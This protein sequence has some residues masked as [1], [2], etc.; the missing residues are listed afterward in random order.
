MTLVWVIGSGGL[1]GGALASELSKTQSTLFNPEFRFTW[2]NTDLVYEELEKA[3][4]A[5]SNQA[6]HDPWQIY[7]AAGVGTM[8]SSEEALQQETSILDAF[9]TVLLS[10][11]YLNLK[12]GTFIFSSSAGA[13]YAG[14]REGV[15]DKY[16][17][18]APINAYGRNKLLQESIVQ[19]LHQ[20]NLGV[21]VLC[22][23][24]TTLYGVKQNAEKQQ[25]LL[26]EIARRILLNQA[27]HIYVPLETMRDYIDAD[28]AAKMIV[29]AVSQLEAK[30]GIHL[31]IIASE[32][33][34][35]IAQLLAIFKR[36]CKRNLRL[37]TRHDNRSGEYQRVVQ[38]RSEKG[39][40]SNPPLPL[41]LVEGIAKL[42]AA[43]RQKIAK[44]GNQH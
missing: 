8:H 29:H 18:V 2:G 32:V 28:S 37:V 39:L 22:C 42:I 19:R 44:N 14:I 35:S 6:G 7:W 5:F 13:I 43:L 41:N 4:I 16:T 23:R 26:T 20:V 15:V 3:V 33:S 25:G 17:S 34:T 12:A 38:F 27:V 31:R 1:L 30:P 36:I 21:T 9:I 10:K 24:I 40:S 11:Q